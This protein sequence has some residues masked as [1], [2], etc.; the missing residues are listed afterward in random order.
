MGEVVMDV[1]EFDAARNVQALAKQ[2]INSSV[3]E[4]LHTAAE[5]PFTLTTGTQVL[6][7]GQGMYDFPTLQSSVDWQSFYLKYNTTYNNQPKK[8]YP[9]SYSDYIEVWRPV[10]DTGGTG[11]Y[12]APGYVYLTQT[13]S[14]GVTPLPD[15]AYSIEYKYWVYPD[16][17]TNASDECIIPSRFDSVVIDGAMFYML[18]FRSN[19]QGANMYKDKFDQGIKYMRRLLLDDSLYMSSTMLVSRTRSGVNG[20]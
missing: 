3:R 1:T 6:T 11:G 16:E 13:D 15:H 8:L 10:E 17:L 2:A 18:M 20:R 19:E 9:L 5:W 12:T 14:F 4:L 7:V